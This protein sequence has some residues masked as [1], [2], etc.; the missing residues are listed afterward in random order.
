MRIEITHE[1]EYAYAS[2]VFLEPHY[3]RFKPRHTPYAELSSFKMEVSPEPMGISE[4]IDA[5][6][7]TVH[8]SWYEGMHDKLSIK[9]TSVLITKPYNPFFRQKRSGIHEDVCTV[10]SFR[11]KRSEQ[12]RSI[13]IR[14]EFPSETVRTKP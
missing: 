13:R 3:F 2:A 6:N 1:T 14:F 5:E 8:F 9:A 11:Q 7:N 4:Q 12:F 10:L